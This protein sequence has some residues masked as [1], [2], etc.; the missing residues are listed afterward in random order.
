MSNEVQLLRGASSRK[1]IEL[2]ARHRH[3]KCMKCDATPEYEVLWAEGMGHA[4]FCKRHL[5]EWLKASVA[6]CAKEGF[7]NKNCELNSIKK[8]DNKQASK[9]FGDNKNGNVLYSFLS[10]IPMPEVNKEAKKEKE[11][12]WHEQEPVGLRDAEELAPVNPSDKSEGEEITLERV[13]PY[14]KSFYKAKPYVSLVGGLANN[15]KTKGD[16]DIFIRNKTEDVA[17]EFRIY[18]MFPEELRN[19]IHILY[20]TEDDLGVYTNYVDLFDLKLEGRNVK[21][22]ELMAAIDERKGIKLFT[23]SKLLKPEHGRYKGEIYTVENLIEILN[24]KPEWYEKGIYVQKKFDGVHVRCDVQRHYES[25]FNV[26]IWTEE[27]NEITD[28]LPTL[29]AALGTASKGHAMALVG[30]LEFWKDKTHQSRQETTAIIHTKE[31]HPDEGKVVLN[32]FDMLFYNKEDLHREPYTKRLERLRKRLGPSESIQIAQ[33][34]LVG[35]ANDLKK[36][37]KRYAGLP[38]SE[39]AYLKRA[40]FP[41]ELDGKTQLNYKYKNTFSIDAEVQDVHV[42]KGGTSWNYG[43][44]IKDTN[45]RDVAIG[46]TY[47]TG[48][49]LKKGDIVKVEFVNLNKYFDIKQKKVWYNW[50]S[51]RVIPPKREKKYPD[52]TDTADRLVKASHG[53]DKDRRAKIGLDADEYMSPPDETRTWLGM[54]H[55]HGRGKSV[56]GDLRFEMSKSWAIGWTLYIPKGL[57]KVPGSYSEF[58]ELVEKEIM[59]VVEAKLKDPTKRFNC[60]KKQPEPV[61]WLDY[62]GMVEP[63]GIGATKNEPGFFYIADRFDV[64]YGAQKPHYHEY[65]CN[66]KLISGRF[67]ISL[68]ENKKEWKRTDEGLMTWMAVAAKDKTPYVLSGRAMSKKWVPEF[69]HSALPQKMRTKVPEAYMYWKYRETSKQ[70]AIRDELVRELGKKLMEQDAM[71]PAIYKVFRQTWKGPTVIREGP[72]TTRYY[73]AICQD[74]KGNAKFA[75]ATQNNPLE[76]KELACV[77]YEH[78]TELCELEAKVTDVK[79]GTKLNE[80]KETPSKIELLERGKASILSRT[81]FRRFRLRDGKL[82]GTWIAFQREEGSTIWT[83]KLANPE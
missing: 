17:T 34:S 81:N 38:G 61:E 35:N 74:T 9:K 13:L 21:H 1:E 59:P 8:L 15:G 58:V 14:F 51:P 25:G 54:L 2:D 75:L 63:G 24:L 49:K 56:H 36:E 64:E 50:W 67:C 70:R 77:R 60:S 26:R 3:D 83:L 31:V 20:P 6:S 47:N 23:F 66:G 65:F 40:D 48:L 46:R 30:E 12:A 32:V 73:F 29:R 52:N 18:R 22:V 33:T 76:N 37:V 68:L 71:G 11:E 27:G 45:G 42:V 39:G 57:S 62:K 5:K 44:S 19:R 55:I 7:S 79:P 82:E 72:S 43:C 4:W 16:I 78:A 41:Y 80:T 69:G 28:K 10:K 53:E